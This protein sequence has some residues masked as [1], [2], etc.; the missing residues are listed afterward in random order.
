MKYDSN[1]IDKYYTRVNETYFRNDDSPIEPQSEKRKCLLA[2]MGNICG[3]DFSKENIPAEFKKIEGPQVLQKIRRCICSQ[4]EDY[5]R[6]YIIEHKE[7]EIQ[8]CIG[9]DCFNNLFGKEYHQELLDF[10][11]DTCKNCNKCISRKCQSRINFCSKECKKMY[12]YE[13]CIKC[14]TPKCTEHQ[15]KFKLCYSCFNKQK[16]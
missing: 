14:N 10:S 1:Y 16:S 8:F 9:I 2:V 15:R 4:C 3:S 12:G 6:H 13:C 7:S 11:K 5:L